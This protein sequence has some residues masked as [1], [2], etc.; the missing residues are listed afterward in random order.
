MTVWNT[1][2]IPTAHCLWVFLRQGQDSY[3]IRCPAVVLGLGKRWKEV[4]NSGE[5]VCASAG[6]MGGHGWPWVPW[7]AIVLKPSAAGY[8]WEFS[9]RGPWFPEKNRRTQVFEM[10]GW[11]DCHLKSLRLWHRPIIYL[12]AELLH[13]GWLFYIFWYGGHA[14]WYTNLIE[15]WHIHN[16]YSHMRILVR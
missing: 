15:M 6:A 2:T 7:V 14:W 4:R 16:M 10:V 11:L 9:V 13:Y 1:R 12:I 8:H 3:L 5:F